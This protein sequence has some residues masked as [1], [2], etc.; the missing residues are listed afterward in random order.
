M[1]FSA[2]RNSQHSANSGRSLLGLILAPLP[3]RI[4]D[5]LS[6]PEAETML[7]KAP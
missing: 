6:L 4:S 1:G 7:E 2:F 3:Y 5:Q